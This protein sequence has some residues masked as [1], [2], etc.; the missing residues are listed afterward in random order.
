M[1]LPSSNVAR[2]RGVN[3]S[4]TLNDVGTINRRLKIFAPN[5]SQPSGIEPVLEPVL[6]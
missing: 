4:P 2:P 3:V 5:L 6:A 1:V